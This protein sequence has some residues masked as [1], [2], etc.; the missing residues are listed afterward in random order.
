[1][2]H[3]GE[4]L[5]TVASMVPLCQTMA[6]IGTDH[7]YVP[8][9]LALSGQCQH[10]IASDIAEGPC[11]AAG[12][13]KNKYNLFGQ[14]EIRTAPGLQGLHAGEAEAVVIA[15]MG[16]AT[17]VSILEEAPGVAATVETFVL[18][19]MNAAN[20]LRRWLV[21]HGYRIADE[22]LCKENGHIYVIIKA[23]HTEKKQKLS[24]IE[25]ELGPCIMEK[26]PALWQEFIQEKSEHY[27]RLLRQMEVSSAA[28]NSEKYKDMKNMLVKVDALINKSV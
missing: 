9:Y 18:Q 24:A 17:I 16:G 25:E 6:D 1:M 20:L 19:P 15:G 11:R 10:V 5:K 3:I 22:A 13:T 21:Q 12:E 27:R 7:G 23:I 28:M 4:R 8:A 26:K 14:M 2:I